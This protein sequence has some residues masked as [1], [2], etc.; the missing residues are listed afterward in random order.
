M[1]LATIMHNGARRI[2]QIE[3][4]VA[5]ILAVQADGLGVVSALRGPADG[6]TIVETVP[7]DSIEFL[8]PV[9]QPPRIFGIGLNQTLKRGTD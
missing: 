2:A 6:R 3:G 1:K 4:K 5:Q 9:P 8:A 7:V